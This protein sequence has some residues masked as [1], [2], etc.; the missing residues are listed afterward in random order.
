MQNAY[1]PNQNPVGL[2]RF[3]AQMSPQEISHNSVSTMPSLTFASSSSQTRSSPFASSSNHS[4]PPLF[5][6][7]GDQ[8]EEHLLPPDTP[9]RRHHVPEGLLPE[10]DRGNEGAEAD[11]EIPDPVND[12]EDWVNYDSDRAQE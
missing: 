5:K 8:P 6:A 11:E 2:Y 7:P 1:V 12:W 9:H 4:P 10:L 3:P